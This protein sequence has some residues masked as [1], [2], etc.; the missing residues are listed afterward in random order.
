MSA[1]RLVI[2]VSAL[3]YPQSGILSFQPS[4]CVPALSPVTV[5]SR[6]IISRRTSNPLVP[7]SCTSDLSSADHCMCLQIIFSYLLT[8]LLTNLLSSAVNCTAVLLKLLSV[9]NINL[10]PHDIYS[11]WTTQHSYQWSIK[12]WAAT[13]TQ[14]A[15]PYHCAGT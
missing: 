7:S 6:P 4:E 12:T 2:V 14:H 3:Q 15:I 9:Q 13:V 8:Y 1:L 5:T 10:K 11:S